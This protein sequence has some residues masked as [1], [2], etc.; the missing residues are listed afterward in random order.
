MSD[1]R[2]EDGLNHLGHT[3]GICHSCVVSHCESMTSRV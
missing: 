1:G 2:G 3:I